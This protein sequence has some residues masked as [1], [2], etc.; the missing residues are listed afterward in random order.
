M[1]LFLVNIRINWHFQN[2]KSNIFLGGG[3]PTNL[4]SGL[5]LWCMI[6]W[7]FRQFSENFWKSLQRGQKSLKNR[8]KHHYQYVYIMNKII[9][10]LLVDKEYLFL[11]ST[12]Y[13]TGRYIPYLCMP[14]HYPLKAAWPSGL[15]CWICNREVPG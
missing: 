7:V 15:G 11:C 8:Q 9:H 13:L 14:M 5:Y 12:L 4:A 1:K 2:P 3:K 10:R 6:C